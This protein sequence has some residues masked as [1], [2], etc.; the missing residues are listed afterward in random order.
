MPSAIGIPIAFQPAG[1]AA[2]GAFSVAPQCAACPQRSVCLPAGLGERA[3]QALDGLRF[4]R[5][6]VA[7]GATLFR[8][9][10]AFHFL[11]A[12]RSGTFKT[13]GA[14]RDGREQVN[15][16]HLAGDL[17]GLDG[18]ADGRHASEAVALEDSEVCALPYGQL[19]Q[20]AREHPGI[21]RAL[22]QLLGRHIV[23]K[24]RN[25]TLLGC[26]SAEERVADFL[27]DL[28]GRMQARGY[29]ARE[30]H[31]RMSRAEIGSYL[32]LTLET[33]SR[34]LSAFRRQGL[35]DVT[36]KQIRL[37]DA[38]SLVRGYGAALH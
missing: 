21:Q 4:A 24:Q 26:M 17:L 11:H 37:V 6:R 20:V 15:G 31:L 14:A 33:V 36:R 32:G 9:G 27:L 13:V 7:A 38:D 3:L 16:F 25:V 10:E 12:V 22:T 2:A 19:V 8:Q 29:S 1:V 34:V 30:F 5:R 35:L 28:S 18:L 23:G